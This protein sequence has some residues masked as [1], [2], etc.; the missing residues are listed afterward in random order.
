VANAKEAYQLYRKTIA[1]E[2]WKKLEAGGASRQRPLWASTGTK[3]KA[4]KDTLYVDDLIG[5]DTVNTMPPGTLEAFNDHGLVAETVT[6]GVPEA[7]RQLAKLSELG[8]SLD[9]VC[10]DLTRDGVKLF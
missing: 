9:K 10:E 1:A 3:N 6:L 7:R 5:S 2:R 8:I 4:Y